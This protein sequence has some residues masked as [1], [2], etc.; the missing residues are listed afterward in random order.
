MREAL[1]K[2][3][4]DPPATGERVLLLTPRRNIETW[5]WWLQSD[6][7]VNEQADHKAQMKGTDVKALAQRLAEIC[8]GQRRSASEM[9][10]SLEDTC[11]QYRRVIGVVVAKGRDD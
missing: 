10:P 4:T 1:R 7:A 11:N 9:P 3:N 8:R 2:A 6:A 5:F